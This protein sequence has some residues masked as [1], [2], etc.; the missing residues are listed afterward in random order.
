MAT[1]EAAV[2]HLETIE[3]GTA[4]PGEREAAEWIAEQLRALGCEAHTEPEQVHGGYWVPVGAPAA[5][6][7]GLALLALRGG[8]TARIAALVGA[9]AATASVLDDI[10]GGRQ[11]AR[12]WLPKRESRNVVAV[13]GDPGGERTLVFVAHHDAGHGGAVF[14]HTLAD[15]IEER[16]PG[17]I[18]RFK[19]YPPIMWPTIAGPLFTALG[20]L[21]GSRRLLGAGALF[22][23]GTAAAMADI[24][25]A[26]VS[27]GAS[28]NLSAV[29]VLL[30]VAEVL[31]AQ[32]VRGVRVLLVSTG[33]E[34]SFMEGMRRFMDRWSA[35]LPKDRTTVVCL[36]TLGCPRLALIEGEGMAWMTDYPQAT[37]DLVA[38]VAGEAG[39]ELVRGLRT[40]A[41][42]DGLIALRAG[43]PSALLASVD[44]R[45]IPSHWHCACDVADNVSFDTV[46]QATAL[47][48]ALARRLAN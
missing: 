2:R 20:A 23:A 26:P 46:D 17:F 44:Q 11:A 4:S 39:V 15:T 14:D 10:S 35:D 40:R 24:A 1:A 6:A 18:G 13:G 45:N 30:G 37:R 28:D 22:G 43:Y 3:R 32:P 38:D 5:A 36:E 12:R 8:R 7:A 16:W 19:T 31:Q 21:T 25:R 33:S 27:P 47:C 9:A 48:V 42:T 41:A 29:G 34:E